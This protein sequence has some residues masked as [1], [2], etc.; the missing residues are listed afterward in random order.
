MMRRV[1]S[2]FHE[3]FPTSVGIIPLAQPPPRLGQRRL[4]R[5]VVSGNDY[6]PVTA[7]DFEKA[8]VWIKWIGRHR[9]YDRIDVKE[10]KFHE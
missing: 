7:A 9:D 6:R 1:M 8:I 2:V 5:A 10:V 4:E 3:S